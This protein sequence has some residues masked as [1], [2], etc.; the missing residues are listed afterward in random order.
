MKGSLCGARV[1]CLLLLAGSPAMALQGAG[2]GGGMRGGG[3]AGGMRGGGFPG[4]MPGG[5]F[6]MRGGGFPGGMPRGGG[7]FGTSSGFHGG[8]GRT[9]HSPGVGGHFV[10]HSGGFHGGFDHFHQVF[11]HRSVFFFGFRNPFFFSSFGNP[12]FFSFGN[13][14][15]FPSS[16]IVLVNEPFF[17]PPFGFSVNSPFQVATGSHVFLGA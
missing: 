3:F 14:F 2:F 17:F 8:F 10:T 5:G 16:R 12:F 9:F 7:R 11:P 15:F 4:G 13:P 1:L 6:G